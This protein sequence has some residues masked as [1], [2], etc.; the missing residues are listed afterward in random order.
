MWSFDLRHQRH[1]VDGWLCFDYDLPLEKKFTELIRI[2]PLML[3]YLTINQVDSCHGCVCGPLTWD[4]K[5][6]LWVDNSVLIMTY[7]SLVRGYLKCHILDTT[8][9][10]QRWLCDQDEIIRPRY[11]RILTQGMRC[12]EILGQGSGNI[13]ERVPDDF[14]T[15][16][17]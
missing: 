11:L 16:Q 7:E 8:W 17:Y 3:L 9:S 13:G 14:Y 5:D 4:T 1:L 10:Q 6:I 2:N 12:D 15:Y